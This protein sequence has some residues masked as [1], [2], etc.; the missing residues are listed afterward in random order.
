[1]VDYKVDLRIE[2]PRGQTFDLEQLRSYLAQLADDFASA[3]VIEISLVSEN[4]D[5]QNSIAETLTAPN[6]VTCERKQKLIAYIGRCPPKMAPMPKPVPIPLPGEPRQSEA[7]NE[8][9]KPTK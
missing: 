8:S 7:A 1:M 4:P 6:P 2:T 9:G 3:D 5:V